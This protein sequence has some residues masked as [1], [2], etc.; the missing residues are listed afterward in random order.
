MA[1]DSASPSPCD[2]GHMGS[3]SNVKNDRDER[4]ALICTNDSTTLSAEG[5]DTTVVHRPPAGESQSSGRTKEIQSTPKGC[6]TTVV[7]RPPAGESQSLGR[8]K[9]IQST[10]KGRRIHVVMPN[11]SFI[12]GVVKSLS[13]LN[14]MVFTGLPGSGKTSI[15]NETV[16]SV[17]QNFTTGTNVRHPKDMKELEGIRTDKATFLIVDEYIKS[18]FNKN[19]IDALLKNVE[20]VVKAGKGKVHALICVPDTLSKNVEEFLKNSSLQYEI[21]DL[22]VK[23]YTEKDWGAIFDTHMQSRIDWIRNQKYQTGDIDKYREAYIKCKPIHIGKPRIPLLLFQNEYYFKNASKFLENPYDSILQRITALSESWWSSNV[24]HFVFLVIVMLHNGEAK[25]EDIDRDMVNE[26]CRVFQVRTL[27]FPN[28]LQLDELEQYGNIVSIRCRE[29]VRVTFDVL[30]K[31]RKDLI[32]KYC[33]D[34]LFLERVSLREVRKR[35]LLAI[36]ER[37]QSMI[38]AG[39]PYVGEHNILEELRSKCST[40]HKETGF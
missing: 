18:W 15:A 11:I 20:N 37:F 13:S 25:S 23:G 21:Y 32:I 31:K 16:V 2:A 17:C 28:D 33:D 26:I 39:T 9:E 22:N 27:T 34:E 35:D 19:I 3:R 6:D 1:E 7:H 36:Y 38:S 24:R 4:E 30:W 5:S 29:T 8:T 40:L 12:D 10:T 14:I